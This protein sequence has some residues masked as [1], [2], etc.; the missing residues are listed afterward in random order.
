MEIKANIKEVKYIS[1][2]ADNLETISLR[3]F[4]INKCP[5]SCIVKD[6][7]NTYAISKWVSPKRTRSYPFER[8]YNTLSYSKKITVIP[9]IKDEGLDGDRDFLQFDTISLMSLLNVYVIYGYYI[10][11]E[12]NNNYKN[13]ITKQEFNNRYI[14]AKLRELNNYH[15]SALHWNLNEL[16][17]INILLEKNKKV[18]EKLEE[19]LK[20]K[21]HNKS[22]IDSFGK[23]ISS[24]V[25]LFKEQS[26][27][28]SQQAQNREFQTIQPKEYLHSISKCKITIQNY[29]G[30]LYYLTIDESK[31]AK[32]N[33]T[34]I[35]SK[36]SNSNKLP[37]KSDIRDGLLKMVLYSNLDKVFIINDLYNLTPVLKLVS[38][39]IKNTIDN[40]SSKKKMD[41]FIASNSFKENEKKSITTLLKE[42]NENNFIIQISGK[43]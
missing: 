20:V 7:D 11:A 23:S 39:S 43:E 1:Y 34:I 29:L 14:K 33:L 13:K 27:V 2:F 36:Y 25:D 6:G 10:K 38:S 12:K 3:K 40:K 28:K 30:G 24:E 15:S 32:K 18:F 17:K 37:S 31:L 9:V 4:N 16:S 22:G 5:T 21:F 42:A 19:R 41:E 8:V 35:E 26:R